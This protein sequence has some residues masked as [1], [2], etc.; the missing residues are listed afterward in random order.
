MRNREKMSREYI[1]N[2]LIDD[3]KYVISILKEVKDNK[4]DVVVL[5]KDIPEYL[6]EQVRDNLINIGFIIKG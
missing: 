3:Y 5:K 1:I 2:K 6:K 4:E